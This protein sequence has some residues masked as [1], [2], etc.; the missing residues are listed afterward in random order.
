MPLLSDDLLRRLQTRA[1][2][3]ERRTDAPPTTRGHTVSVGDFAV[4]GLDLGALLRGEA[5]P[6][7]RPVETPLAAPLDDDVIAAAE[8]RLGFALPAEVRRLYAEVADGGFGPGA[9]LLPLDRVVETY[10]DRIA[11]PPGWRG[12]VWPARLLPLT[13]TDPGNDCIDTGTGEMIYWDEE[14][15]ASGPSDK[16]WRRSFKPDAP[17]LA[18]WLERWVGKPSPEEAQ[19]AMMDEAMLASLR[20]TIAYWRAKTPEQRKDYGLPETGWEQALFG[21]LGIDLSQL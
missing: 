11:N 9:G 17:D 2:D 4:Q 18:T 15:L 13:W 16:V 21:H 8:A 5:D 14:E 6:H 19:R 20:P 1:A 10:L 7:T 3:P 12:Q